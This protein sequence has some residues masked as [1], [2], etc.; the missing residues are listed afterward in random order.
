MAAM[1]VHTARS[2]SQTFDEGIHLVSGYGYWKAADFTRNQEH[3]PLSKLIAA[4]PLLV[5]PLDL[6]REGSTL[7]RAIQFVYENRIDPASLLLA[8]RCAIAVVT[9]A[10][11]FALYQ[12]T[13][14]RY[15]S[16]A[17]LMALAF[18]ALDPN[19]I[20]HGKY[21]TSDVLVAA[22][23]FGAAMSWD[24]ALRSGLSWRSVAWAALLLGLAL[25]SKF[26]ALCLI[27]MHL[28][29]AA[30]YL[31]RGAKFDP[32]RAAAMFAGALVTVALT[33]GPESF[34]PHQPLQSVIGGTSPAAQALRQVAADF[35]LPAHPY[36]YGV[37]EL[38]THVEA[39]HPTYLN[40]RVSESGDW[41]YFP[42]AFALKTPLAL[43]L[44]VAGTLIFL[45]RFEPW[46]IYPAVYFLT[47][48]W[49]N[50]NIGIRHLLP[51]Y[52]FLCVLVGVTFAQHLRRA[53]PP[54]FALFLVAAAG[55]HLFETARAFPHFT[56]FFNTIA[57]GPANGHRY[58]LDSNLDWGQDTERLGRF[59]ARNRLPAI[60]VSYF[61]TARLDKHGV[62]ATGVPDL[63]P[64]DFDC[65][66]AVSANVAAGL[67]VP[68]DRHPWIRGLKPDFTIGHSIRIYDLRRDK[69]VQLLR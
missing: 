49:G 12:W 21:V 20:A 34:R 38:A 45:R 61:G 16:E 63:R 29:L 52:P 6:P 42:V 1:L 9:I 39:S 27:P 37:S 35:R 22:L 11:G 53:L 55:I 2:E 57:G 3:P 59:V 31:W 33:Y 36:L 13:R 41:R 17:A 40:G 58:L 54:V 65:V 32:R 19:W 51:V 66:T 69:T 30:W 25:S 24:E 48:M 44:G 64:A 15:S 7:D 8:A 10:F 46:M 18:Y 28:A 60:C 67:Y 50:L 68:P 56:A 4:L 47:S 14:R 43:L 62:P 5:V 26:S 23:F